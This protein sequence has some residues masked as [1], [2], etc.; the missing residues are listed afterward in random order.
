MFERSAPERHDSLPDIPEPSENPMLVGHE[1]VRAML[2]GAFRSGKMHH[3]LLFAGAR[4]IGKATLGFHLARH[5]F[6][7]PDGAA[8]E[9]LG[10]ADP[11]SRTFRLV[12]QDAHPGLLHLTRP[13]SDR[14]KKFK[15]VITVDEVRRV[16]RFLSMTPPDGGPRFVIVDPV[17]DMNINAANAL[18]K[19]LEEPPANTTFILIAHSLGRLLPTIRSRCQVFKF[20]PLSAALLKELLVQLGV[21]LPTSDEKRA[22]LME[23]AGGSARSAILMTQFGG[24]EIAKAMDEIT[25]RRVLDVFECHRLGEAV[26]ARD[27]Q[28]QFD[29][30]NNSVLDRLSGAAVGAAQEGAMGRA[31]HLSE[32]WEGLRETIAQAEIYNLDRKQ[33]VVGLMARLHNALH[34]R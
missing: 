18:L 15:T 14:D 22:L 16:S 25:S 34:E 9:A 31:A 21:E 20:Q 32:L 6:D 3:A 23:R 29:L 24:L 17:D 33:H 2:A 8:S 12:A 26:A 30:F 28:V 27:R 1:E 11:S 7:H 4:G 10:E 5:L 19:N 13:Q